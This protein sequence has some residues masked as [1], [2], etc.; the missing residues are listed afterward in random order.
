MMGMLL[1]WRPSPP[2]SHFLVYFSFLLFFHFSFRL[3]LSSSLFSIAHWLFF[4]IFACSVFT[5][6]FSYVFFSCLT[7]FLSVNCRYRFFLV[8]WFV[9]ISKYHFSSF[10]FTTL[11][12]SF[13]DHRICYQFLSNHSHCN[14]QRV[15]ISTTII[16]QRACNTKFAAVLQRVARCRF[17]TLMGLANERLAPAAAIRLV[18]MRCCNRGASKQAS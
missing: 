2:L 10:C 18:Q 14:I 13:L 1:V 7:L 11:L 9:R 6:L 17:E 12:V 16:L 8:S 4:F 3:P 15:C 5:H